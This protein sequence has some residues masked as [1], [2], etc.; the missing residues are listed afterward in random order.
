MKHCPNE[1]GDGLISFKLFLKYFGN[2]PR[3]RFHSPKNRAKG[4]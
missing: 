1:T 4:C 3:A 2:L